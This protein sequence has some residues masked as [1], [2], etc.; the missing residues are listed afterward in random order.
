MALI[1]CP[2]CGKDVSNLSKLCI[3]C[4]YPLTNDSEILN[5]N[6]TCIIMGKEYDLSLIRDKLLSDSPVNQNVHNEAISLLYNTV[7]GMS[8]FDAAL[9]VD[10]IEE[11]SEIP[12]TYDKYDFATTQKYDDLI[13]CPKCNSTQITTGSRG[14]SIVS[15]FIGAGKTVNR[16]ARC[17]YKWTPKRSL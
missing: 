12:T 13:H 15:G 2:E 9:L 14:F 6:T 5:Q 1:K 11:T 7:N 16:C 4:G 10:K 8:L 3:H 17:G